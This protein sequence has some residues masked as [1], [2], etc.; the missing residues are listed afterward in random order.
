MDT[1]FVSSTT[2]SVIKT[3]EETS[4]QETKTLE[5][6]KSEFFKAIFFISTLFTV[7][8]VVFISILV[9][10]NRKAKKNKPIFTISDYD[11]DSDSEFEIETFL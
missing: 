10:L 2:S 9:Y 6:A 11:S 5:E 7:L 8:S 3:L 1:H 4:T